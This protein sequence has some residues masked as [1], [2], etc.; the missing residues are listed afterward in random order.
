MEMRLDE[1]KSPRGAK[2]KAKRVGRG[3]GSG[4]GTTGGRGSKGQRSRSGG[5]VPPGFEG[6]QMPLQRRLP[7]RGFYNVFKKVFA[8]INVRDLE[9]FAADS[10]V[11]EELLRQSGLVR[12]K[13]D[14]VKLLGDGEINKPLTVKVDRCS[15]GARQKIEAAGG[16][17]EVA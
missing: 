15:A 2:K 6:G 8:E 9:P 13:F 10:V 3:P 1:L 16:K 12:G 4:Q 14:G 17:I 11:D 5:G 7:K